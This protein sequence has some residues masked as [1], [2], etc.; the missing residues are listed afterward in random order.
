MSW[1]RMR[2]AGNGMTLKIQRPGAATM[3]LTG[4]G[5]A[6]ARYG[7]TTPRSSGGY[8]V[9]RPDH[10]ALSGTDLYY[11]DVFGS[12]AC[13]VSFEVDGV[14]YTFRKGLPYPTGEDGAPANLE[15]LAMAPAVAGEIDR[16]GGQVP[17]GAPQEEAMG[18]VSALYEGDPP[19]FRRDAG[20]G[21]AMMATF[22]RGNGTVFNAGT[23][24]WVNGLMERDPFT[25]KI[26]HN[27]LRRFQGEQQ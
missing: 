17:L 25:E 7:A 4:L 5:G 24:E 22:N 2:C 8:T 12:E 20:Y 10:W 23:C 26:T 11:G 15:I 18:L 1:R 19:E 14:D 16:W 13:I 3:G 6:Y 9:Y 21:A 27:V